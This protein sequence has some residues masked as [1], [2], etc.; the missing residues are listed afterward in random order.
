MFFNV[1]GRINYTYILLKKAVTS[2]G[3][4]DSKSLK[5]TGVSGKSVDSLDNTDNIPNSCEFCC[6][7]YKVQ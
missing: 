6:Y 4:T 1:G 2:V 7:K 5:V 3:Q